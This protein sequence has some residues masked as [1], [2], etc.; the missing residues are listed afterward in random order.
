MVYMTTVWNVKF[1]REEI[2]SKS[3]FI[4]TLLENI[5]QINN[6]FYKHSYKQ[7]TKQNVNVAARDEKNKRFNTVNCLSQLNENVL[8]P[9]R[10]K[11]LT[12]EYDVKEI[13]NVEQYDDRPNNN[14]TRTT[15]K[16]SYVS[17]ANLN[18]N[19]CN[20]PSKIANNQTYLI[21]HKRPITIGNRR[22]ENQDIP[23]KR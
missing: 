11:Q 13:T 21:T 23:W 4:K 20:R 17:E 12:M 9:N 7:R 8:S 22:P 18:L 15:T 10:F 1:P 14:P 3:Y 16:E 6:S 19:N 2:S 5:F